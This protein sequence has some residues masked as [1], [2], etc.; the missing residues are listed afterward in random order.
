MALA[1]LSIQLYS[2]REQMMSDVPGTL[3][4]LARL[5]LTRVEPWNFVQTAPELKAALVSSGMT[6]PTAHQH[7][8]GVDDLGAVVR[9]AAD[10]GIETVIEPMVAPDRWSTRD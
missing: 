2:V 1:D 3:A 5:G 10:L 4:R 8:V 6:A 7:L 9:T